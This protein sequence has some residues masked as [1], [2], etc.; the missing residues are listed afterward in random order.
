MTQLKIAQRRGQQ[1]FTLIELVVTMIL[2]AI[3]SV[4]ASSKFVDF[5]NDARK[6]VMK[7][8]GGSMNSSLDEIYALA[9]LKGKEQGN[10]SITIE[11][12]NVPL[13]DGYPAVDSSVGFPEINA[14]LKAW[15]DLDIVDRNT[16]NANRNSGVLFSDKSTGGQ[17]LFVFFTDHYD[18]KGAIDCYVKYENKENGPIVEVVT[19]EC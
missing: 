18:Q 16:A 3:L 11:G 14:Q 13:K 15:V 7:A 19:N 9:I 12:V 1:G 4:V 8:V 10:N 2:L 5:Q 6:S 17:M